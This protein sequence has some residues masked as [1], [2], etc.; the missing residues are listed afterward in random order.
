MPF[1]LPETSSEVVIPQTR[2][3]Y[4]FFGGLAAR[5]PLSNKFSVLLD[6][7]YSVRGFGYLSS[8]EISRVR[9]EYL[10]YKINP[11]FVQLANDVDFGIVPGVTLRFDRV[12]VLARYQHGLVASSEVEVTDDNGATLGTV[13]RKNRTFQIGLGF[14]IL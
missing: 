10:W 5:Q 11:D 1:R 8:N 6:A 14:R 7:S 4:A 9:F 13:D 12:S 3:E 2:T